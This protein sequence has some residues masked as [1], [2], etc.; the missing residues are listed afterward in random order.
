MNEIEEKTLLIRMKH[1]CLHFIVCL[2]LALAGTASGRAQT[3]Y[4]VSGTVCET[5][6][7]TRVPLPMAV[8]DLLTTDSTTVDRVQTDE[9]GRFK[10]TAKSA[11]NYLV[12]ITFLGFKTH[13]AA[14]KL[15]PES[16]QK[17]LGSVVLVPDSRLMN[18][19]RV[20]EMGQKLVIKA[21]TFLYNA[22]A[23][24][25]PPGATLA[26]L[27]KQLPGLEVNDEGK[28]T[29]QGKEVEEVLVDGKPFFGSDIQTALANLPAEILQNV[30][31]YEKS[32]LYTQQTSVEDDEKKTVIDLTIK[33]EY[34]YNWLTT[35][36]GSG[37]T[38]GR[39][40]NKVYAMT[41]TDRLKI[42]AYGNLNNVSANQRID[43]NG[44]WY[45]D[46]SGS[47][48]STYRTGGLTLQYNNGK[49]ENEKGYLLLQG[50]VDGYH[51][52][53]RNVTLSS[54]EY[55]R[56]DVPGNS[57][58][59][60]SDARNGNTRLA[61]SLGLQWKPD[62]QTFLRIQQD[63]VFEQGCLNNHTQTST[64]SRMQT[65]DAPYETLLR[66][67]LTDEQ[68]SEGVYA[69]LARQRNF[70]HDINTHTE[71][72]LIRNLKKEKRNLELSGSLHFAF[73]RSGYHQ[74]TGYT[75][76]HPD[77]LQDNTIQRQYS[78][79]AD[80]EKNFYLHASYNEPLSKHLH[81]KVFYDFFHQKNTND[82][83]LYQLDSLT[84]WRNMDLPLTALPPGELLQTV[85]NEVNSSFISTHTNLHGGGL[86]LI[87]QWKKTTFNITTPLGSRNDHLHYRRGQTDTTL[88]RQLT[89]WQ[90]HFYG[91]YKPSDKA[92][93]RLFYS[94]RQR[95]IDMLFLVPYTDTSDPMVTYRNTAVSTPI[96]SNR[97]RLLFNGYHGKR[98]ISY[99]TNVGY[100][101][102]SKEVSQKMEY[103]P[104]SGKRIYSRALVDG[105][106]QAWVEA[107][108]NI[109][110]D[111]LRRL[112][113]SPS[114][115]TVHTLRNG[116]ES[117]GA[118]TYGLSCKR[119]NQVSV[120]LNLDYR[121]DK[122]QVGTRGTY[123]GAKS[124]NDLNRAAD[125]SPSIYEWG[126]SGQVELPFGLTIA[127]DIGTYTRR[128]YKDGFMNNTQVLWNAQVWQNFLKDKNLT[129]KVEAV[130][131]L[132]QRTS[133][134]SETTL[135]TRLSQSTRQFMSYVLFHAI[136]R[137]SYNP[138]K[139]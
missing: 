34:K 73:N 92:C 78:R 19:L 98:K 133:E 87:G 115:N 99:Y 85:L 84:A 8:A 120:R 70:R 59:Q 121:R 111:T 6:E 108:T 67:D 105:M 97:T 71:I 86:R 75:Y 44:N 36:D 90:V 25:L 17:K 3:L 68:R 1:F 58:Y 40:F 135:L 9:Q 35:L 53:N 37:G 57:E 114:L 129:L 23:Y 103:D 64:Y 81:L 62:S 130:D 119:F 63:Y 33:K 113:L 110:L 16:P 52:N 50:N 132:S 106:R 109:P 89:E 104:V 131:I 38:N 55:F 94:G 47:G 13:H 76:F 5:Q 2:C 11:G 122:W 91:S 14:V 128:G 41:F 77:A 32:S 4:T 27:V 136:Y 66:P 79:K 10:L 95:P 69:S 7:T 112:T 28:L 82:N 123:T 21:D 96:W 83:P 30:K 117:I 43:A 26:T 125:E 15:T 48:I 24:R 65:G 93:F 39:F 126:A 74:L 60:R 88:T 31:A 29:F 107:G 101:N 139:K 102:Q 42:A 124:R 56:L 118:N 45:N 54:Q 18:E 61:A 137:F 127:S 22:S 134:R 46:W 20:Q 72:Q 51:N 12:R 49:R 116:Y 100:N 80:N 138:K